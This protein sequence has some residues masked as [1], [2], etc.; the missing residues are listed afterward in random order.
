MSGIC[1]GFNR[2]QFFD[3][4][5]FAGG[6]NDSVIFRIDFLINTMTSSTDHTH[7]PHC[8]KQGDEKTPCQCQPNKANKYENGSN[9]ESGKVIAPWDGGVLQHAYLLMSTAFVLG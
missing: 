3:R 8:P 1:G 5:D 4:A 2:V 7:C 9:M 6:I